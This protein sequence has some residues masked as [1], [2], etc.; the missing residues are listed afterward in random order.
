MWGRGSKWDSQK[1]IPGPTGSGQSFSVITGQLISPGLICAHS[2]T[3]Q[4]SSGKSICLLFSFLLL[5]Y[6]MFL[7]TFSMFYLIY[8]LTAHTQLLLPHKVIIFPFLPLPNASFVV[9]KQ[10]PLTEQ[11]KTHQKRQP[12]LINRTTVCVNKDCIYM[13]S[14]QFVIWTWCP[15]R[16]RYTS[17][18]P[19][20]LDPRC[21]HFP[22]EKQCDLLCLQGF[23]LNPKWA[24][25]NPRSVH[26]V[27]LATS[28]WLILQISKWLFENIVLQELSYP[29][30]TSLTMKIP[31]KS[32]II[33]FTKGKMFTSWS[34]VYFQCKQTQLKF[35]WPN[36]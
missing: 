2:I 18:S 34:H 24:C 28:I 4:S 30:C 13:Q 17:H 19:A 31:L 6:F 12:L 32:W 1:P 29:C 36:T 5:F 27:W 35:F 25:H 21:T 3:F 23:A 20:C 8:I 22:Q 16:L 7:N 33:S 10:L 11:A 9:I 15:C 26:A 14:G